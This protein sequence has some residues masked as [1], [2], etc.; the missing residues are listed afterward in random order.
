MAGK[1]ILSFSIYTNASKILSTQQGAGSL[2]AING[3]RF[4]TMTWVILGHTCIF[5]LNFG[6]VGT[7]AFMS[8]FNIS[9]VWCV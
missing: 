8:I 6:T 9:D 3:I 7:Y 5:A 1:I 2:T 4:I